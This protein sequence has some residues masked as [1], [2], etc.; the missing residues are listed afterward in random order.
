TLAFAMVETAAA[1]ACVDTIAS[2]PGIDGL[3][4]GPYDLAT[5][6]SGGSA[7]HGHATQVGQAID[8]SCAAGKKH[9]KI[10]GSYFLAAESAVAMAKRGYRFVIAGNDQTTL[11]A[12]TATQLK[13]LKS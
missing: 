12:A 7:Q 10:P 9:G 8:T 6:L 2:T 13:A 3:F 1:L 4:V 11:R 5:A